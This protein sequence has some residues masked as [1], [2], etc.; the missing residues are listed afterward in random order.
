MTP[1]THIVTG[2]LFGTRF[3]NLGVALAAAFALHFA[4]DAIYHFEAFY[5]LSV[6][7][8]WTYAQTMLVLS[9]GV[10]LLAAPVLIWLW[11]RDRRVWF[12][13]CY[14]L[15]A[16]SL[17]FEPRWYARLA[18]GGLISVFWMAISNSET[19]R[20]ILCGFASYLPD[21]LKQPLP[22]LGELHDAVHYRANLELGDW[23]SLLGQGRWK[24]HVNQRVFDPYYRTG[25]TLEIMLEAAIL[26]GC[27]YWLTT[28]NRARVAVAAV[29]PPQAAREETSVIGN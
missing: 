10:G 14:A 5:E 3:R 27:L 8:R 4:L 17:A 28:R 24:I 22:A 23:V 19:R 29:G 25:Y 21:C 26:F 12:F 16:C 11:R 7:G 2:A 6:P 15:I 1:A 13:A 18:L 20:W 9:V